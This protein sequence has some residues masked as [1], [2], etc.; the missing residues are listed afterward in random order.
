VFSCVTLDTRRG[1][2]HCE[3]HISRLE[4]QV[5]HYVIGRAK[6]RRRR[7]RGAPPLSKERQVP[8]V[9][10]SD[11]CGPLHLQSR[12]TFVGMQCNGV[13]DEASHAQKDLRKGV[14]SASR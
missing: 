3:R 9:P 13:V 8:E 7:K 2:L 11:R 12:R 4:A 1:H 14:G 6:T 5:T 10:V